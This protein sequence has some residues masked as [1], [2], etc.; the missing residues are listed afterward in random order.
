MIRAL[1]WPSGWIA[2]GAALWLARERWD[3]S[4]LELVGLC[5]LSALAAGVLDAAWGEV[6][7]AAREGW[8]R[9]SSEEDEREGEE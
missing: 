8:R 9:G 2:A 6:R 1:S 3:L 5:F 7:G 4:W